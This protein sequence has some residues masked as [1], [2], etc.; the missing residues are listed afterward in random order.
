[1]RYCTGFLEAKTLLTIAVADKPSTM[2]IM[3]IRISRAKDTEVAEASIECL[4]FKV[5]NARVCLTATSEKSIIRS[6]KLSLSHC[7][8]AICK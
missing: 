5:V 7:F 8:H 4:T 6:S 2:A 3:L 1:M